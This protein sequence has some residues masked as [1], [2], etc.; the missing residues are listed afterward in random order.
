MNLA[1]VRLVFTRHNGSK[2]ETSV[3]TYANGTFCTDFKPDSLG[4]WRVTAKFEGDNVKYGAAE[5][6]PSTFV[7]EES[8][9]FKNE[10]YIYIAAGTAV[11]A[12][13]LIV[14]IRMYRGREEI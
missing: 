10:F 7:V 12:V 13:V 14:V 5:S 6:Y 3:Y 2:V 4:T 1:Q 8:V 11:G 9:G